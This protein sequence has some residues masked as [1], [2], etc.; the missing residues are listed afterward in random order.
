MTFDIWFFNPNHKHH[1]SAMVIYCFLTG[2][3]MIFIGNAG[4]NISEFFALTCFILS[5]V[6]FVSGFYF[7]IDKKR[8][9]PSNKDFKHKLRDHF[10][11]QLNYK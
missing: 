11:I 8:K 6:S 2:I 10:G 7:I 5:G 4:I 1:R 9:K 3:I